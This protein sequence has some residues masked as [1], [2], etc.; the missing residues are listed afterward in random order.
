MFYFEISL[1]FVALDNGL[2]YF[3]Q[4]FEIKIFKKHFFPIYFIKN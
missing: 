1:G 3:S 4:D 2:Y